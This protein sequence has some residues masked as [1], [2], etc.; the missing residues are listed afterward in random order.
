MRDVLS[1]VLLD[2][3]WVDIIRNRH[4][5]ST[6]LFALKALTHPTGLIILVN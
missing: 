1:Y 6:I 5:F 4:T 3:P 2:K